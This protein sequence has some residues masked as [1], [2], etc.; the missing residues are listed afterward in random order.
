[1]GIGFNNEDKTPKTIFHAYLGKPGYYAVG[2]TSVAGN[3]KE[4][5]EGGRDS[6]LILQPSIV[7]YGDYLRLEGDFA[8]VLGF[9][10]GNPVTIRPLKEGDLQKIVDDHNKKSENQQSNQKEPNLIIL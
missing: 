4:I 6:Y 1:M 5:K 9:A 2:N 7:G 8:T 10:P 3:L